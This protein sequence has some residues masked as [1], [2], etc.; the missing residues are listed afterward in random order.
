MSIGD[1][2][3]IEY[4]REKRT[5]KPL[6]PTQYGGSAG[7]IQGAPES[8]GSGPVGVAS[9][10]RAA[11]L[12]HDPA[13]S[14]SEQRGMAVRSRPDYPGDPDDMTAEQKRVADAQ[15]NIPAKDYATDLDAPTLKRL[16]P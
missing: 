11:G 6:P 7:L 5:N 9:R 12:V 15:G 3:P 8:D 10:A 2:G 13:F 14:A 1:V 4:V 16:A